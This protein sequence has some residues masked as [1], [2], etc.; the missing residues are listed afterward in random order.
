VRSISFDFG[1]PWY[2]LLLALLPLV[3]FLSRRSLAGL[4]S[5][6]RVAAILLRGS[7]FLLVTLALAEIRALKTSDR[8]AVIYVI[9][10]SESIPAVSREAARQ[11]AV[12]TA[13]AQRD[14][15]REDLV[16]V[17]SFG[18]TAGIEWIPKPEDLDLESFTT[19]VEPDGSDIAAG[20]RLAA[21]AFPEGCAKRIVLLTDGNE[22]QGQALDEARTARGQGISVDVIPI[23]YAY[24][25]ELLVEKILITPEIAR[26][27]PFDVRVV[28]NS[29]HAATASLRLFEN[30]RLIERPNSAVTLRPGRNVFDFRGLH[31][32]ERGLY[33]YEARLEPDDPQD[34][35]L[36]ENNAAF[37]F[38][39]VSGEARLLICSS[40]PA[41]E[42]P[43]VDALRSE[44]IEVEVTAPEYLPRRPEA[45]LDYDAIVVSNV[46]A[47][48]LSEERMQM[49]E[50]L[51][52]TV[53]MGFVMVGGPDSF[54]AGGYQG[55]PVER[56]LPVEMDLNSGRS[57]RTA[58]SPWSSIPARSETAMSGRGK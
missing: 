50:A 26:G 23:H 40:E 33:H 7:V 43:L 18:K 9:D 35:S 31:I 11:Y 10:R 39:V 15:A 48:Q 22:N 13:G 51:V 45:Y 52:R 53:G 49:F 37:G 55:T 34:D 29:T 14:A 32:E 20:V 1:A 2:V 28:V 12:E 19:L 57:C 30:D 42:A 56:L 47:Y 25:R 58:P 21:A 4:S 38:T 46:A 36:L 41:S 27:D 6:R 3:Y 44:R 54:G 24:D 5:P 17:V 8:L 16:G